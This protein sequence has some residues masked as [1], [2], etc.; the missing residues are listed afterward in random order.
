[1]DGGSS[2]RTHDQ[3]APVTEVKPTS[4]R[5]LLVLLAAVSLGLW[6]LV[7]LATLVRSEEFD[8][9]WVL[10]IPG[11]EH[12]LSSGFLAVPTDTPGWQI[13]MVSTSTL[14]GLPLER[15]LFMP[16]GGLAA[17][18]TSYVLF[19]RLVGSGYP[20]LLMSAFVTIE[21]ARGPSTYSTFAH[22]W[23]YPLLFVFMNVYL[24]VLQASAGRSRWILASLVL[25]VGLHVIYYTGELVAILFVVILTVYSELGRAVRIVARAE[26]RIALNLA[27][28]LSVVFLVF[29]QVVYQV[30]LPR[31]AHTSIEDSFSWVFGR[32]GSLLV[33]PRSPPEPYRLFSSQN[34]LI[35]WIAALQFV[36]ILVPIGYLIASTARRALGRKPNASPAARLDLII[37]WT[38]TTLTAAYL[39]I[40]FIL[41]QVNISLVVLLLPVAALWVVRRLSQSHHPRLRWIPVAL[42]LVLVVTS[43]VKFASAV[44]QKEIGRSSTLADVSPSASWYLNT[45]PAADNNILV[46]L[47]SAARFALVGGEMNA[48]LQFVVYNS[49]LFGSVVG[50]Q[51]I[52]L[53]QMGIDFVAVDLRS[54]QSPTYGGNW[55]VF[56]PL[57]TYY[58]GVEANT[59]LNAIY[60]DGSVAI[61]SVSK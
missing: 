23:T 38:I 53:T 50:A 60:N 55:Q 36:L 14:T 7:I 52:S 47:H 31:L 15:L 48:P 5:R 10:T 26:V 32:L 21:I 20:T 59:Y 27:L 22:A 3:A 35:T 61:F 4:T 45:R 51:G 33:A 34:S 40:Y 41:G 1:M 24:G 25:F 44:A 11:I 9:Y 18:P 43:G 2:L 57:G 46:D 54:L 8:P 42:C 39:A 17:F 16:F 30:F 37:V 19:R 13:L 28:G 58:E 56:Q 12:A 29:N 6:I 49:T